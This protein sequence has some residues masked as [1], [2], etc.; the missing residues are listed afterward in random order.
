MK[1]NVHNKAAGSIALL[2]IVNGFIIFVGI[3]VKCA[4]I[5]K[6]MPQL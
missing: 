3:V 5:L 6:T 4:M 1:Q 2:F